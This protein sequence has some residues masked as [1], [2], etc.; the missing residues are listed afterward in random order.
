MYD[1]HTHSRSLP[2]Q[3]P[4]QASETPRVGVR[5]GSGFAEQSEE[6]REHARLEDPDRLSEFRLVIF[7]PPARGTRTMTIE[8]G[9][10]IESGGDISGP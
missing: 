6:Q 3:V 9:L 7:L 8:L 1:M 2:S 5:D 10:P 4:F